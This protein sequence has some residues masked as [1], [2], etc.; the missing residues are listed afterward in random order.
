[1][2]QKRNIVF[3]TAV[4]LTVA[5]LLLICSAFVYA[6]PDE[7]D[8]IRQAIK[9]KGARWHADKTSVSELTWK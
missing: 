6:S 7:L 1:M 3:S 9:D 2:V 8:Q 4:S 5:V